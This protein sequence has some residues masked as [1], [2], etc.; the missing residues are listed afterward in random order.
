MSP[1]LTPDFGRAVSKA[2]EAEGLGGGVRPVGAEEGEL[3]G[4][5]FQ[6]N[7]GLLGQER[8]TP[9]W[10]ACGRGQTAEG[11]PGLGLS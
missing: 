5:Q 7:S 2:E 4:R 3:Q 9:S 6:L 1:F 11:T 10:E 8:S